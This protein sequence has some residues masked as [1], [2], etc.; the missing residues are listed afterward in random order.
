MLINTHAQHVRAIRK[1]PRFLRTY[2]QR[3]LRREFERGIALDRDLLRVS[4]GGLTVL[5]DLAVAGIM[6]S[7]AFPFL[8]PPSPSSSV[9]HVL[10]RQSRGR[11][12]DFFLGEDLMCEGRGWLASHSVPK[13]WAAEGRHARREWEAAFQSLLP[14]QR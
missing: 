10:Q 6:Q 4:G 5:D 12:D 14:L 7:S 9:L 1:A 11:V 13:C 3:E 8:T 2:M